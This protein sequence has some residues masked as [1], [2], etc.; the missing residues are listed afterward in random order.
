MRTGWIRSSN[1]IQMFKEISVEATASHNKALFDCPSLDFWMEVNYPEYL[2]DAVKALSG[3]LYV[4]SDFNGDTV[5]VSH[6]TL[7]RT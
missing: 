5:Y 1:A 4:D 7:D 6:D 3:A 2:T